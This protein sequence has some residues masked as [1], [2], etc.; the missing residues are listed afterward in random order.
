MDRWSWP[1]RRSLR[2][3][4]SGTRYVHCG[5]KSLTWRAAWAAWAAWAGWPE[6]SNQGGFQRYH[7]PKQT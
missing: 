7:K 6:R 2:Q 3:E 4:R 5:L 1:I